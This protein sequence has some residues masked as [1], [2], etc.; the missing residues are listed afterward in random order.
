M[1]IVYYYSRGPGVAGVAFLSFVS[2]RSIGGLSS[3]SLRTLGAR[4]A[5]GSEGTNQARFTRQTLVVFSG[6]NVSL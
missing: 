5:S 6:E 3:L 2:G 1:L 4:V